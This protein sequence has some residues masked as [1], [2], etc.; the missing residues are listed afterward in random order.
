LGYVH[1]LP[2]PEKVSLNY[3]N[4]MGVE[5]DVVL[6]RKN[7]STVDSPQSRNTVLSNGAG[8]V[9]VHHEEEL[10]RVS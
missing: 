3:A 1:I 5:V 7:K 9:K 10:V 2:K 8:A 6:D 4:H